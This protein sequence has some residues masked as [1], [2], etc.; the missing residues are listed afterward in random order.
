MPAIENLCCSEVKQSVVVVQF[1]RCSSRGLNI[2][3]PQ[4]ENMSMLQYYGTGPHEES[5]EV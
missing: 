5:T 3:A 1:A 4:L 2:W